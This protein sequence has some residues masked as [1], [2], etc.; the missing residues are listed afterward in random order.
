[1]ISAPENGAAFVRSL[2]PTGGDSMFSWA[3][4]FLIIAIIAGV[5]GLTG[6]AGTAAHIAWIFFVIGIILAIVF[7]VMGRR[8]PPL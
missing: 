3:I 1:M 6:I 7:T 8:R 4:S 5:L 2:T